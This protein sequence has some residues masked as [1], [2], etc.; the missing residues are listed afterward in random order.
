M[1]GQFTIAGMA[2]GLDS[3]EK[4]VGPDTMTGS[5]VVGQIEDVTLATGDNIVMVPAGATKVAGFFPATAT[6]TVNLRTNL[7]LLDTGFP[8][9]ASGPWFVVPLVTG[10]TEL[11]L[12]VTSGGASVELTF[13]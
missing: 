8:L 12:A 6:G 2:T 13:I 1:A 11:I 10:T 7:N 3:G 9:N 5:N 4:I